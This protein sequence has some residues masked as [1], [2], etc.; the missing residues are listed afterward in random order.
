MLRRYRRDPPKQQ[1]MVDAKGRVTQSWSSV[2]DDLWRPSTACDVDATYDPGN[3]VSG[4]WELVS[5]A[6]QGAR[7]GNFVA[8]SF[9]PNSPYVEITG[10]VGAS[11][12]ITVKLWNVGPGAVDLPAGTIRVRFW[13]HNP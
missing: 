2:F 11:D 3:L 4:A 5:I 9:E 12:Q 1:P 7:Q 13:S 8:A 10:W 6:A